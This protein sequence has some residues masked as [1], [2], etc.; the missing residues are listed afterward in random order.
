MIGT[1]INAACIV[2]GGIVGKLAA[3]AVGPAA[4]QRIRLLLAVATIYVASEMIWTGLNGG[5]LRGLGQLGIAFLSLILGNATGMVLRLQRGLNRLGEF[6]K[7]AM[8]GADQSDNRFNEGFITCT[9]LFCVGPMA[10]LGAIE[11]GLGGNFKI[12]AVKG[13][14]DGLATVGFTAM[15]GVGCALAVVPVVAYQ[16]TI[17]LCAGAL[18]PLLDAAMLDS[19]RVTGGLLV[20]TIV[21]VILNLR[22]VPLANY[23]PALVFAPLLTRWWM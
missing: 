3:N 23:L 12:L 13:C 19:I 9:I 7:Q 18:K 6:A 4:Q 11:D 1:L 8:A 14:M 16:G 5:F 2:I 15:F 17:T 21:V 22:K 10:I 20:F